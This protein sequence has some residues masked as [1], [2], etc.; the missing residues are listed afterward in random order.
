MKEEK[1]QEEEKEG[2]DEQD[3]D[4]LFSEVKYPEGHQRVGEQVLLEVTLGKAWPDDLKFFATGPY[5]TNQ[6]CSINEQQSGTYVLSFKPWKVGEHQFHFQKDGLEVDN[7]PYVFL[8]NDPSRC[9]VDSSQ[10]ASVLPVDKPVMFIVDTSRCG[11]GEISVNTKAPP[12]QMEK[13]VML[14]NVH[15]K[16]WQLKYTPRL[17]GAHNI[18]VLFD[19]VCAPSCPIELRVCNPSAC[20]A[21]GEGIRTA[22]IDADAEFQVDVTNAGPGRLTANMTGPSERGTDALQLSMA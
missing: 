14:T 18:E 2:V 13:E 22:I 6:V 10:L 1:A 16:L 3:G 20:T 15:D 12:N 17:P 9:R 11:E 5:R 21:S 4:K 7:F 19:N 8:V